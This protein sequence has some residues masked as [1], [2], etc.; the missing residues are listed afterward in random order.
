MP[1]AL[2]MWMAQAT[3]QLREGGMA[4]FVANFQISIA[5]GSSFGGLVVD[6]VG[7]SDAMYTGA[8]LAALAGCIL[9]FSH[10]AHRTKVAPSLCA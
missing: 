8:V 5:L 1:V 2:Q 7:L 3:P 4:L 6:R 10:R 9:A